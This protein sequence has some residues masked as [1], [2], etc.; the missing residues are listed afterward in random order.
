VSAEPRAQI[1]DIRYRLD[2]GERVGR[3]RAVWSFARWS[4]LRALGLYRDWKAK[5]GPFAMI[6]AALAPAISVLGVRALIA[7]T[8]DIQLPTDIIS[9]R[10]YAGIVGTAI[11]V[12]AAIVAPRLV[13]EDRSERVLPLYFSTAVG[14]REYVGAKLL[15]ALLPM[16]LVTIA[17]PLFLFVGNIVFATEPLNYLFDN[18]ADVGRIMLGGTAMAVYYATFALAVAS[19]TGRTAFAVAGFIGIVLGSGAVSGVVGAS[20]QDFESAPALALS[21][22]PIRVYES[23]FPDGAATDDG[24]PIASHLITFFLVIGISLVV[25]AGRYRRGE[26]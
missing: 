25:L 15:A 22:V 21:F 10:E 4:G 26:G 3:K 18:V 17:P 8:A 14:P 16:L 20:M 24:G 7:D 5:V 11:L 23:V 13:C 19:L 6:V 9:Y 12:F 1:F 2:D